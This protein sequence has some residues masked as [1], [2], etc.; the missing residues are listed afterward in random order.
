M[1]D[2]TSL[3]YQYLLV[4]REL[5]NSNAG[6]ILTGL[7]KNVLSKLAEMSIEEIEEL[8]TTSGLCLI[9]LRFNETQMMK[10]LSMPSTY[11]ASYAMSISAD[12]K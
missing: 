2:I 10:M 3:N 4:A 7:P 6:R 5:A 1:K 8:A 11:R 9:G 12:Q